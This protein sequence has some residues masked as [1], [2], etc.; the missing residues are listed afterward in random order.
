METFTLW[1]SLVS[2]QPILGC[3]FITDVY[4]Q[5]ACVDA[6]MLAVIKEELQFCSV[7]ECN[8]NKEDEK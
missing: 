5:S 1:L 8:L 4:K 3:T 6:G 7:H 2:I